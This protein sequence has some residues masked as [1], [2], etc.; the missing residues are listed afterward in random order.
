[1]NF[2]DLIFSL[3]IGVSL[4]KHFKHLGLDFAACGAGTYP[5]LSNRDVHSSYRVISKSGKYYYIYLQVAYLHDSA[6]HLRL[7]KVTSIVLYDF[8]TSK[9]V[10]KTHLDSLLDLKT[11]YAGIDTVLL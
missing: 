8:D 6:S 1:M 11:F 4:C 9:A 7:S 5:S 3:Q 10:V 2:N